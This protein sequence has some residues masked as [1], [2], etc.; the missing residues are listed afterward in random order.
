MRSAPF[1]ALH[2]SSISSS[3][4]LSIQ[5]EDSTSRIPAKIQQINM[6]QDI[7]HV[8]ALAVKPSTTFAPKIRNSLQ[9]SMAGS[10]SF[11]ASLEETLINLILPGAPALPLTPRK[12]SEVLGWMK[13][14]GRIAGPKPSDVLCSIPPTRARRFLFSRVNAEQEPENVVELVAIKPALMDVIPTLPPSMAVPAMKEVP[15]RITLLRHRALKSGMELPSRQVSGEERVADWET[16]SSSDWDD[17]EERRRN[18]F[19][20]WNGYD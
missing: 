12:P 15:L 4:S 19:E 11:F 16:D 14:N 2:C 13:R 3:S 10:T 6:R 7:Q 8:A 17:D 18:E 20:G 9:R 5:S 1:A